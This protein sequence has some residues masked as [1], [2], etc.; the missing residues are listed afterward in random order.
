M[1][2]FNGGLGLA[3]RDRLLSPLWKRASISIGNLTK[4]E[5]RGLIQIPPG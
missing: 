2:D 1:R 4:E 3:S 5:L